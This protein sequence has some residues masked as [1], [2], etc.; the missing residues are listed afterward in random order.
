MNDP[1]ETLQLFDEFDASSISQAFAAALAGG[2]PLT[3]ARAAMDAIRDPIERAAAEVLAPSMSQ[4]A[5]R[6]R[7]DGGVGEADPSV[8]IV[9]RALAVAAD[10]IDRDMASG[11]IRPHRSR[12]V[13]Q[14]LPR[15]PGHLEP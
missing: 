3:E 8:E 14:V 11:A 9:L 4:A 5:R 13:D 12:L 7:A 15:L 2:V 6:K 10:A 1:F